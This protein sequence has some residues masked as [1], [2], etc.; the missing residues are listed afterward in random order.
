MFFLPE[1]DFSCVL[2][3]N[4]AF[5]P[6]GDKSVSRVGEFVLDTNRPCYIGNI[7]RAIHSVSVAEV[8]DK[9]SGTS[10]Y[11]FLRKRAPWLDDK[12]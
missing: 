12:V 1:R 3:R 11:V 4:F 5:L 8:C 7:I 10:R 9:K 6:R 2:S